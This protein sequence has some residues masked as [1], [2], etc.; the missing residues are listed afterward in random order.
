MAKACAV[1][2]ISR[3]LLQHLFSEAPP[4]PGGFSLVGK[5]SRCP[6]PRSNRIL[7]G[8]IE[9]AL[10]PRSPARTWPVSAP[11]EVAVGS[12]LQLWG[13]I[14]CSTVRVG[15]TWRDQVRETGHHERA[16]DLDHL[17]ALGLRTLRYPI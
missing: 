6:I 8:T 12:E 16:T 5:C 15:N 17:A 7:G 14:E 3:N 13:G 4:P 9:A 2:I 11:P 10:K 1:C